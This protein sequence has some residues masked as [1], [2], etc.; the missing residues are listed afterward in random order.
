VACADLDGEAARQTAVAIAERGGDALDLQADARSG[1]D[2]ERSVAAALERWGRLDV[3]FN[4]AGFGS[5]SR[6]HELA[7]ADWDLALDTNLKAVYLWS[8]VAIPHFLRQERG[9]IVNT[10]S[11]FGLFGSP[12]YPNYCASKGGII[13]LTRQMALDYGPEI[14][15]N[16]ICPGATD[17]PRIQ[18]N[19]RGAPDPAERERA[20]AAGNRALKRLGRPEEIAYAALFLASDESSFVTGHALVVDGGQT[21]AAGP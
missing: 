5:R 20:L 11:T 3:L 10:A 7:E 6:V 13:A 16:C 12:A 4:N 9:N 8:K 18:R 15:V 19:I 21:I 1:A 17:T 2:A 14:R